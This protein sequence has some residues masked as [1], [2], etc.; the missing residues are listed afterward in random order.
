MASQPEQPSQAASRRERLG[1]FDDEGHEA[2]PGHQA[3]ASLGFTPTGTAGGVTA[4]ATPPAKDAEAASPL[5]MQ[6]PESPGCGI[7]L[8]NTDLYDSDSS[9]ALTGPALRRSELST[10]T[11]PGGSAGPPPNSSDVPLPKFRRAASYEL[12]NLDN[13]EKAL[14]LTWKGDPTL[15]FDELDLNMTVD[16]VARWGPNMTVVGRYTNPY[17]DTTWS[18]AIP[19]H[20][21]QLSGVETEQEFRHIFAIRGH[22]Q[23]RDRTRSPVRLLQARD[24][25]ETVAS[26]PGGPG[27]TGTAGTV[28]HHED[29]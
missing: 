6:L 23:D 5:P 11:L 13:N 17:M 21:L 16:G 8:W 12:R 2:S 10:D 22:G 28:E 20:M 27:V 18:F 7:F 29:Q 4:G 15:E 24:S 9:D 19:L 14:A 26:S 1:G 3:A 25:H